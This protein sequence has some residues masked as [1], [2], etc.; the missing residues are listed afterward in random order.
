MYCVVLF[1][2]LV[3]RR[4]RRSREE[5]WR[6]EGWQVKTQLFALFELFQLF[7]DIYKQLRQARQCTVW[8]CLRGLSIKGCV[9]LE[10]SGGGGW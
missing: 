3:S 8:C 9:D 4:L 6:G 10:R 5:W 2:W 1:A 7:G